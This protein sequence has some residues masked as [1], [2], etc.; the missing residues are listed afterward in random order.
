MPKPKD[1]P[2]NEITLAIERL[3]AQGAQCFQKWT[4]EQCGERFGMDEPNTLYKTG[5]CESCNHVTNIEERGCN[6]AIVMRGPIARRFLQGSWEP[7]DECPHRH[8]HKPH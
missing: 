4:C 7:A 6:Y 3:A 8:K 5:Y 1:Y 2:F